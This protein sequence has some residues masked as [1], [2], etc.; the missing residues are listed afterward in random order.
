[1]HI[2]VHASCC[3]EEETY[4]VHTYT[5]TYTRFCFKPHLVE[6][7]QTKVHSPPGII[8][9]RALAE[10]DLGTLPEEAELGDLSC[11][12]ERGGPRVAAPPSS[13]EALEAEVVSGLSTPSPREEGSWST[14]SEKSPNGRRKGGRIWGWGSNRMYLLVL[15]LTSRKTKICE[16]IDFSKTHFLCAVS[17]YYIFNTLHIHISTHYKYKPP[18]ASLP[19]RVEPLRVLPGVV[20]SGSS[21]GS[22]PM[23]KFTLLGSSRATELSPSPSSASAEMA[24]LGSRPERSPVLALS[25]SEEWESDGLENT[26]RHLNI[27]PFLITKS[28]SI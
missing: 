1:M 20:A 13:P 8:S 10:T 3:T 9:E 6:T 7:D 21:W 12:S 17:F 11:V 26:H 2:Q 4:R 15:V 27:N 14:C 25:A 19:D 22:S 5:N 16:P 18:T 24:N 23:E 28:G